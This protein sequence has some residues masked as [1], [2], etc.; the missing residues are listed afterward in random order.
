MIKQF[1]IDLLLFE[2]GIGIMLLGT[3][4]AKGFHGWAIVMVVIKALL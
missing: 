2:S 3:P 4:R 1:T